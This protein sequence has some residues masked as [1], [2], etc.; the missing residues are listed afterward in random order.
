MTRPDNEPTFRQIQAGVLVLREYNHDF[1]D[2]LFDDQI[3]VVAE[4]WKAMMDAKTADKK[5]DYQA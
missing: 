2:E 5:W 3:Q 4:I 1:T